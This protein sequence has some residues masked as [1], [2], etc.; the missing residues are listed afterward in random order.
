MK[1]SYS[2]MKVSY[3]SMIVGEGR[4]SSIKVRR[5]YARA[6]VSLFVHGRMQRF[7]CFT[8]PECWCVYWEADFNLNYLSANIQ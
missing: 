1:A 7:I 4:L 5:F 6:I 3:S 8:N 2:S